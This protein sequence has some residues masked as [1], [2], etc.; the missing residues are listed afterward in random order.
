[1]LGNIAFEE[2]NYEEAIMHFQK[3]ITLRSSLDGIK[4][5]L[6]QSYIKNNQ[7]DMAKELLIKAASEKNTRYEALLA[8]AYLANY[9]NDSQ[10]TLKHLKQISPTESFTPYSTY[11]MSII[12]K[13]HVFFKQGNID[14]AIETLLPITR[15]FQPQN[16]APTQDQ[17]VLLLVGYLHLLN[18]NSSDANTYFDSI[19]TTGII[20]YTYPE[21]IDTD[22]NDRTT[23]HAWNTIFSKC[24]SEGYLHQREIIKSSCLDSNYETVVKLLYDTFRIHLSDRIYYRKTFLPGAQC[25]HVFTYDDVQ[26]EW[27]SDT[28]ILYLLVGKEMEQSQERTLKRFYGQLWIRELEPETSYIDSIYILVTDKN[29]TQVKLLPDIPDLRYTDEKYTILDYGDDI[30]LSFEQYKYIQNPKHVSVVATGYYI[31]YLNTYTISTK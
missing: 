30:L 21:L 26:Q 31:P 12:L 9:Q 23:I 22:T 1:M 19:R 28:T 5:N 27:M 14:L 8:L 15:E 25:P 17:F 6:S 18:N 4:I 7:R 20:F 16:G 11:S 3:T 2:N 13:S 24:R 10:S 29:G